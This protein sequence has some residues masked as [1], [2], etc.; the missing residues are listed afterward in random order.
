VLASQTAAFAQETTGILADYATTTW[1]EK[2]GLPSS[3]IAAIA[4]TPDEYLWLGTDAGLVRFDGARFLLWKEFSNLDLPTRRVWAL[5]TSR[6]GSLWV[7]FS[8]PGGVSRVHNG[9]VT[10]YGEAD[11]LTG[12]SVNSLIEGHDGTI[13]V[14]THFGLFRFRDDSWT[15]MGPE[16]G[17][18]DESVSSTFEDSQGTLW[19]GTTNGVFRRTAHSDTF[20]RV[21]SASYWGHRVTED[22]SGRIWITDPR[23][24]AR[25]LSALAAAPADATAPP[26]GTSPTEGLGVQML[27]DRHNNLWIATLGQ[28]L[29]RMH[30]SN[31]E[32]PTIDK[33]NIN[34]GLLSNSVRAVLEDHKGNVWIGTENGLQQ[35]SEKTLTGLTGLGLVRVIEAGADGSVWVG[36][37]TGLVRFRNGRRDRYGLHGELPSPFVT[38]LHTDRQGAL[39]I[40]TDRGVTQFINERFV[41]LSVSLTRTLSRVYSMATDARG[42]LWLCDANQGLFRWSGTAL[43]PVDLA[44]HID[45]RMV[46]SVHR[47][48]T[49]QIWVG[50]SDG[51][52]GVIDGDNVFHR[53][54]PRNAR[55]NTIHQGQG[56]TLWV[57]SGEGAIRISDNAQS[58]VGERNGLPTSVVT[59]IVS[60]TNGHVWLGTPV[61]IV[62]LS[63]GAFDTTARD[64]RARVAYTLYDTEDGMAGLTVSLGVP[65]AIRARD[66]R[67]WFVTSNGVTIIDPKTVKDGATV[68]P[69]HI[70]GLAADA[71][72]FSPSPGLRIPPLTSTIEIDYAAVTFSSPKKVRYRY[73]LEGFDDDWHDV[74]IRREALYTNLPPGHYR[75]RVS[76]ANNEL[77]F[78]DGETTTDFTLL[79]TFY[80]TVWFYAGCALTLVLALWGAWRFRVRHLHREF[81]LVL[82]ERVRV[83]REIHDTLLQSLVGVALQLDA[84]SE[85]ADPLGCMKDAL[86]STRR[87]VEDYIRE[88]RQSIWNLRSPKLER[89]DLAAA[90]RQTG[91][92]V[93]SGTPVHFT[94]TTTGQT[95]RFKADIEQQ[96][97]RIGEQAMLNSVRH[98]K[99]T[100]VHLK[101]QYDED[102]VLLRV[103]DNGSGFNP[104]ALTN[105]SSQ[106][107]GLTSM[108]ER[109][110][111][112]GGELNIVTHPGGGTAVEIV[113]PV[114][115]G[116]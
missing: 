66:G 100:E 85:A 29:W 32:P 12:G 7:G 34:N 72:R 56:G 57:S 59:A 93:T 102:A 81:S 94:L 10:N 47:D 49:N 50:L 16:S 13:W 82:G 104:G 64:A 54:G 79:P 70:E 3:R 42:N 22:R 1:T 67:L 78:G 89:S 20:E 95:H 98:A 55:L 91:E 76:A 65:N 115:P 25:P 61:G 101:L 106:H 53:E 28:G 17:L 83:S 111:Q 110:E 23:V 86:I 107:Y 80:Q 69:V 21:V 58:T 75:F 35:L 60:D 30:A 27:S 14:G 43:V 73:R 84:L 62:R 63:T 90:L 40:A 46:T 36:T 31:A 15:R 37:T 113:I 39:W 18:A 48:A 51:A 116:K 33:L 24:G 105:E 5:V 99:A 87:E 92:R 97:L 6:D 74:G 4:Q 45:H 112:A 68:P 52:F 19:I 26:P 109:T 2:D 41:P 8:T 9:V 71:H 44:P 88:T 38:A 108:Q 11:G 114:T 96:L 77:G 103:S